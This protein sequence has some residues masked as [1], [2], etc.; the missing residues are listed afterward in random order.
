MAAVIS[1]EHKSSSGVQS[2]LVANNYSLLKKL[3]ALGPK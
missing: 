1:A 3:N 2:R